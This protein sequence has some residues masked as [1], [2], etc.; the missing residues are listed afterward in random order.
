M[1]IYIYLYLFISMY[2]YIY[3]YYLFIVDEQRSVNT[4]ERYKVVQKQEAC[5]TF[6]FVSNNNDSAIK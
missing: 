3:I 2:I 6:L 1:Y 5:S 4:M